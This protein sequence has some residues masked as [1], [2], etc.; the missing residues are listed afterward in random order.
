MNTDIPDEGCSDEQRTERAPPMP[1]E[2]KKGLQLNRIFFTLNADDQDKV[3]A[4]ATS[5]AGKTG[6]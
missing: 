2:V 5:L 6:D 4:L 1:F 3:L